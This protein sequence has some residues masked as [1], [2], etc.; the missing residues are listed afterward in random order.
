MN[1]ATRNQWRPLLTSWSEYA[2]TELTTIMWTRPWSLGVGGALAGTVRVVHRRE[3]LDFI[4]EEPV[5]LA[6][7][8]RVVE[9]QVLRVD[10]LGRVDHRR[11]L[12]CQLVEIVP[13]R[14]HCARPTRGEVAARVRELL[15]AEDRAA[16]EAGRLHRLARHHRRAA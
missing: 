12:V 6:T 15:A 7:Q 13:E 2:A 4:A 1:H 3:A 9:V 5:R 10:E 8:L 16:H 11:L 14:A